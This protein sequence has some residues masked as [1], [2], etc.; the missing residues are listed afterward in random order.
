LDTH[1][2]THVHRGANTELLVAANLQARMWANVDSRIHSIEMADAAV[3]IENRGQA[4]VLTRN[5][6]TDRRLDLEDKSANVLQT[7]GKFNWSELTLFRIVR[8]S[9]F[10]SFS[11]WISG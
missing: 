4:P 7:L 11:S 8:V 6:N 2:V 5:R 3:D 10:R 9:K 1:I